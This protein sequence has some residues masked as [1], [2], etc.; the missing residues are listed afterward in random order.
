LPLGRT[1]NALNQLHLNG[2]LELVQS[3]GLAVGNLLKR[4]ASQTVES[5]LLVLLILPDMELKVAPKLN[6]LQTLPK[7]HNRT[8]ISPS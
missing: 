1:Q 7:S 8:P 6:I 2:L 4:I 3:L 5:Q